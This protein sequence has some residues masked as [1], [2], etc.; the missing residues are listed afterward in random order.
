VEFDDHVH[1]VGRDAKGRLTYDNYIMANKFKD[2]GG[3]PEH[4]TAAD[5]ARMHKVTGE[6]N[7]VKVFDMPRIWDLI[8]W[9][10][11]NPNGA[12]AYKNPLVKP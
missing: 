2:A 6:A 12:F 11:P 5:L 8:V 4:P 1:W 7:V 10:K 9:V 3:D